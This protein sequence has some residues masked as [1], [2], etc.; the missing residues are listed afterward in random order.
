MVVERFAHSDVT[1]APN[2][3]AR[4]R[5]HCPEPFGKTQ[6]SSFNADHRS[7]LW[8]SNVSHTQ[9]YRQRP[10]QSPCRV[11][12]A[13]NPSVRLTDP[14]LSE[15]NDPFH[16]CLTFRTLRRNGSAGFSRPVAFPL[17]RTLRQDS[18]IQF[19]CRR[20]ISFMIVERFAHSDVTAAPDSVALLRFH[21]PEP[22]GKT[23]KSSFNACQRS[24]LW[25][26]LIHI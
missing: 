15:A 4:S 24:L 5:F 13:Q 3:V 17:P 23:Q 12:I 22:V 21:C 6:K 9:T 25:L 26:S 18:E 8:L 11:S 10:I 19:K 1:A 20:T 16:G 7:L 14:V 2:S